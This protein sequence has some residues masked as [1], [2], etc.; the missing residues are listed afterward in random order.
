[1]KPGDTGDQ[2]RTSG[3]IVSGSTQI[4]YTLREPDKTKMKPRNGLNINKKR[5]ITNIQNLLKYINFVNMI[6]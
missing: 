2:T 6:I 4:A 5:I 3:S 1:M